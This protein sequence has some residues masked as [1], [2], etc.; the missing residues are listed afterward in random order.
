AIHKDQPGSVQALLDGGADVNR[1]AGD[2]ET[3]LMMAAGYGYTDIVTLLLK[4]GAD[5]KIP[6]S[7]GYH[8]IDLAAA[9]VP[10]TDRFTLFQCHD[11]T[12]AALRNAAP[13]VR[14]NSKVARWAR[15][16]GCRV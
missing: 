14:V 11:D 7:S 5:P 6:D 13:S 1:L 8:A 16:K 15:A 12:I 4:H 3:A 9:G 2:G 10:D